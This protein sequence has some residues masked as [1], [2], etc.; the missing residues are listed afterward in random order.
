MNA[1]KD[2]MI[3]IYLMPPFFVLTY[4]IYL[5]FAPPPPFHPLHL[6]LLPSTCPGPSHPACSEHVLTTWIRSRSHTRCPALF[7][8]ICLIVSNVGVHKDPSGLPV[9]S[10]NELL[11]A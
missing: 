1:E 6:P 8:C 9:I 10:T 3:P 5:S 4:T 7:E 11:A 2:S